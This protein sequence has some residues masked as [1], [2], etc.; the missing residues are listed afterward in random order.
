MGLMSVIAVGEV[1]FA[2]QLADKPV[3]GRW[4]L[5]RHFNCLGAT[6]SS[7]LLGLFELDW[8]EI[9]LLPVHE[10]DC[11][12]LAIKFIFPPVDL[13]SVMVLV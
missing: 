12:E 10:L 9:P 8:P 6:L 5:I 7:Q 2:N 3:V 13:R 11:M 1:D 4:K